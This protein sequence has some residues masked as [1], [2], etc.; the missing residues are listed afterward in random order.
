MFAGQ[1]AFHPNI[2]LVGTIILHVAKAAREAN[3]LETYSSSQIML[4]DE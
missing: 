1:C 4:P 3:M 2:E